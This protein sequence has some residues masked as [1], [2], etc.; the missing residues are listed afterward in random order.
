MSFM[1][2]ELEA[3]WFMQMD[4]MPDYLGLAGI[5]DDAYAS[6]YML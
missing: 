4:L 6:L 1:L 3:Y 5:M 2:S